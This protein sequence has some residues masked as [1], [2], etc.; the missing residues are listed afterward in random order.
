VDVAEH[1]HGLG[2]DE[3]AVHIDFVEAV[4]EGLLGVVGVVGHALEVVVGVV[5]VV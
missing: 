1:L 4:G 5:Y 2:Q 3:I